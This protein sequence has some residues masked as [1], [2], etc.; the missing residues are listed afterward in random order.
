MSKE[1][2]QLDALEMIEER[3]FTNPVDS[4]QDLE[5][6]QYMLGRLCQIVMQPQGLPDQPRPL[7]LYT[8][9][10]ENRLHRITISKLTD[11]LSCES[12]T[13]VGFCGQKRADIDW[14]PLD[15]IDEEL[16]IE[17]PQHPHLLSYSTLQLK[18]GNSC[19]LVLFDNP[20]GLRHWVQGDRHSLAVSM[21]PGYY[22]TIRLHNAV[23]R[24]GLLAGNELTLVRTKYYDFQTGS[25]W[26]GVRELQPSI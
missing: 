21:T 7:I 12:L 8:T 23:L 9:E 22:K 14:G 15:A 5:T 26:W 25:T 2:A 6:L 20:K 1:Y 3:P 11:L 4:I 10:P 13:V 17:F 19:N 24:G 18:C 16:I